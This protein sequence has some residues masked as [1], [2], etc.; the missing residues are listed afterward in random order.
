V[1]GRVRVHP[2]A[3]GFSAAQLGIRRGALFFPNLSRLVPR[4]D[5]LAPELGVP[6]EPLRLRE[7]LGAPARLDAVQHRV[8][9][10][11]QQ[12]TFDR[13]R[14]RARRRAAR[15]ARLKARLKSRRAYALRL[16][17]NERP[18]PVRRGHGD[19]IAL[20]VQRGAHGRVRARVGSQRRRLVAGEKQRLVLILGGVV[21]VAVAVLSV[22]RTLALRLRR[23]SLREPVEVVV[24][25]ARGG[26]ARGRNRAGRAGRAGG[27]RRCLRGGEV[28]LFHHF[29]HV[30]LVRVASAE[31]RVLLDE[32]IHVEV[33]AEVTHRERGALSRR[34]RRRWT[35]VPCGDRNTEE[36][37]R[38]V[39][40]EFS[41]GGPTVQP[42]D[43]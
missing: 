14:R 11:A 29:H 38:S 4:A 25:R 12:E 32:V 31:A 9:G 5:A 41:K 37:A 24:V 18:P 19:G 43:R 13:R 1:P 26:G 8:D 39:V 33:I 28:L 21:A 6:L 2:Q 42:T 10:L 30:L 7:R 36:A 17:A 16:G 22:D 27:L 3:V 40:F 34:D 20:D 15:A 35:C 23:A